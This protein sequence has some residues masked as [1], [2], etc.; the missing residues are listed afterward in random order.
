MTKLDSTR[1]YINYDEL[2]VKRVKGYGPSNYVNE[3]ITEELLLTPLYKKIEINPTM[4]N[5]KFFPFSDVRVECYCNKCK[6]RR[7]FCFENS[8]LAT[9][10]EGVGGQ[11]SVGRKLNFAKVFNFKAKADCNHILFINFIV[12][13]DKHVM[14]IGQYPSI[15]DLNEEINNRKFLKLLGKE[16]EEYYKSACS[17]YSFNTCIGAMVYL[18]RIFEK[19][20]ID[21]FD[22]H[23]REISISLEEFKSSKIRME[24]KIRI[25]KDFL[26]D[27]LFENGFNTIYSKISNGIHNLTEA[28]CEK[29]FPILK[30]AIE[31][32][33]IDK[34]EMK[35]KEQR[36]K[37]LSK[38]I[39]N[40]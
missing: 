8:E 21:T 31:E 23:N 32:V 18:R 7:I 5:Y 11:L 27:I 22:E 28:E 13:D 3:F 6:K 34:L 39:G 19:I 15:Y 10:N 1:D 35:E 25:L 26:P 36:R 29:I 4:D 12:V 16:Y 33:L 30:G 14:K 2:P 17:L 37:E 24:A 9:Y 38:K 40:L 20:L